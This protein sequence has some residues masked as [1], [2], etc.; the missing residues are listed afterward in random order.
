MSTPSSVG[1]IVTS[2]SPTPH[3]SNNARTMAALSV[4]ER[5]GASGENVDISVV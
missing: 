1:V 5:E 3:L 2:G 4:G